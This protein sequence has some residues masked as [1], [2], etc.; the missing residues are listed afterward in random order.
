[1]LCPIFI[2]SS[3]IYTDQTTNIFNPD[4]AVVLGNGIAG[5]SQIGINGTSA[6][7]N[8]SAAITYDFVDNNTSD[9]DGSADI[10]VHSN[11]T[12]QQYG[13]DSTYDTLTEGGFLGVN[14]YIWIIGDDDLVRKLNISDPGGTGILSWD[15]GT[16]YPFGIEYQFDDGNEYIFLVDKGVNALIKF[17]AN[18]GEEITRWTISGYSGDAEGLAWNGSR[19]FIADRSDDLIYQ[20]DPANPTVA[21]R[22]FSYN[23]I[24]YCTG[25]AGDGSYLWVTD[26]GSDCLLYTSP[27]PRD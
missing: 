6:T 27:S 15:T 22:S 10:G 16:S 19:W 9:V 13:P 23:G 4:I 20:V 14:E 7:V 3:V 11:F 12:A 17:N 21:E 26:E 25:L 24:S 8:A 2:Y 1:M 18:T 5:T